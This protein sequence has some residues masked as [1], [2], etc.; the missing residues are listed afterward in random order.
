MENIKSK[1]YLTLSMF[2]FGT[3]GIFV[4]YIPFSSATVAFWRGF[5]GMLFL[6]IVLIVK[7]KKIY[8][9]NIKKKLILLC[10]SGGFIG[11]NW[12]LLFEAYCY[13]TVATATL[14]YYM[15]PV[16]VIL[17]SVFVF[18]EKLDFKKTICVIFSLI[19]MI[20]V[21]GVLNVKFSFAEFKGVFL[22]LGAALFYSCVILF[23]KKIGSIEPI[24]KTVFQ[25][26][27]AAVVIL[28]Y[29]LI[30]S[31]V[32]AGDITVSSVILLLL[33][34]VVHTGLAYL[35]YFTAIGK[36]KAQTTA[37]LSYIDPVVAIALSAL[38]LKEEIGVLSILGAIIILFSALI[39]ELPQ[40]K[41]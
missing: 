23:N 26:G 7:G 33:V 19:G 36:L 15:A 3:I 12:I 6:L 25:L 27:S 16:I 28:P 17:A 13:T 1:I 11:I 5:M 4:K 32:N 10:L 14:C 21:S 39:N 8:T 34:S 20:F 35:L 29:M 24:P 40:K 30:T 37:V 18:S 2:I 41:K 22:G 38:F 9:E 31:N